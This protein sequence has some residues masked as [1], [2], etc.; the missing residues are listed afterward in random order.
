MPPTDPVYESVRNLP[1]YECPSDT[2]G[3]WAEAG[4]VP[5]GMRSCY[6]MSGTSYDAN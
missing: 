1:V 5:A 6:W 3:F 2:G 4:E